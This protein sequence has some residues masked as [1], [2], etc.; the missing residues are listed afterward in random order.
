MTPEKLKQLMSENDLNVKKVAGM[1]Y[2]T[3]GAVRH[4]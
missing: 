1:V 4:W 3:D 2:V